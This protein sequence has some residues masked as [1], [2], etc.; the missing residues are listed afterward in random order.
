MTKREIPAKTF[1]NWAACF[2]ERT[3]HD[4]YADELA[5]FLEFAANA[6]EF[7][8]ALQDAYNNRPK[9]ERTIN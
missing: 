8:D 2:R 6:T 1:R 5:D 3:L 7:D 9:Y 4:E